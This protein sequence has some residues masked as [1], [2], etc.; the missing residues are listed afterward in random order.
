MND[1]LKN[2]VGELSDK[3]S[4]KSENNRL[5]NCRGNNN[6]P[7]KNESTIDSVQHAAQS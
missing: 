6:V 1:L 4:K 3:Q 7:K 2:L 5:W